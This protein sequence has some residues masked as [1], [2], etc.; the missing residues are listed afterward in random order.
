M[1][2]LE[3][4][5]APRFDCQVASIRCQRRIPSYVLDEVRRRHPIEHIPYSHGDLGL[6]HAIAIDP[7]SGAL[8]GA[9]DTGADGMAL[10]V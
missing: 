6:V 7:E 2:I 5:Y 1:D 4:V 10:V 9:A 3:A 8:R